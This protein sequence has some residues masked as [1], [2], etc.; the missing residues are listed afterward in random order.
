MSHILYVEDDLALGFVTKDNL[1]MARY[2]VTHC[3]TGSDAW[4]AFSRS[5][6]S[7]ARF[8]LCILDVMLPQTDG[9]TVARQI[10]AADEHVPILF[11]SALAD[12]QDR[13]TGLR[14]GADDYLTKPFSIEE[15]LLKISVF[16]KRSQRVEPAC[17]RTAGIRAIGSYLFDAN[18]LTLHRQGH[19]Q[20]LTDREAAVL[21]YLLDRPNA[22][23]RRDELLRAIWGDD[24]YFMGR[25]LDVFISRLRKR[26]HDDAS[27]RIENHH[28]VGFRLITP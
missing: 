26:L 4:A 20:T 28:G 17:S 21:A 24:D 18:N 9:F 25:S 22:L 12:K 16:L 13:L 10:R 15:L 19:T 23:V 1:E 2:T 5:L 11:L 14:T 27:L 6:G 7:A 8:D 3:T